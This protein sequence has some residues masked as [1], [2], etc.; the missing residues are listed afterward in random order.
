MPVREFY[1]RAEAN[2][3]RA[4]ELIAAF[5]VPPAAGAA[6]VLQDRHPQR[7]GDR[8]VLLRPRDRPGSR[9]VGAGL[10]SA[11]ADAAAR[12]RGRGVPRR[13][14]RRGDGWDAPVRSARRSL[15]RFGELVAA[16][17]RPIDDVRGTAAYRRTRWACSPGARSAGP[18]EDGAA[19]ARS[20]CTVNGERREADGVWEGES[21]LYVL[22]ERLG[23]PGSKNACEQGECGS[24]SVYLDGVLVCA[25]L[26]LAGQAEGRES[27][28]SRGCRRGRAAPGPG[29]LRRGGRGAVW[30]L[31]A[32][33]HRRHARP[34]RPRP[35]P[36]RAGD[37]R[38][39]RRQPLPLHR[40]RE[41]PRRRAARGGGAIA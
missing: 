30:L 20:S 29:G 27:S 10:G 35:R 33:A 25:C 22:R 26:V 19:D 31:H 9:R 28:R 37:P 15:E 34:A 23:L 6:A 18:A 39:A 16:A 17:A 8:G 36:D 38:G 14:A 11:G 3:A 41:D 2:V 24:C 40:L 21:L 4:D 13:R 32:R 7:D 1:H 5:H 12:P